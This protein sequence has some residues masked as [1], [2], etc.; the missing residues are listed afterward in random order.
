MK[1]PYADVRFDKSGRET[2]PADREALD[3]LI[4]EEKPT[5]VLVL[6]HG[7]NN[8]PA[9]ARAL[10]ERLV[11]SLAAVRRDVPG[12]RGRRFVVAGMLWPSILWAPPEGDGRGAGVGGDDDALVDDIRACIDDADAT[13]ALIALVPELSSSTQ[14]QARFVEILRSTLPDAT[15]GEDSAA[16]EA[17]READVPTLIDA[18]AA[19]DEETVGAPAV[20]GAAAID[21]TGLPPLVSDEGTG[22]GIFDR[23]LRAGRGLVNVTTYYTMKERAGVVGRDGIAPLLERLH[24]RT[25]GLRLHLVGHSFGGR[26]VTAA[27]LATRAP[28]ASMSLLQAAYSHF[29]M[30]RSYNDAGD[31]GAFADVPGKVAGPIVVT[32]TENDRAVGRAY[33]VASRLARQIG[34]ALGDADDPYGG[35]GRNGAQKTPGARTG[36]LGPVGADYSFAPGRVTSLLSDAFVADHSDVTGRE[37]AYAVLVAAA[38]PPGD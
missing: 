30:A 26:A 11:A 6:T 12:A 20:G 34:V 4:A 19:L 13:E 24:E 18:A 22:A 36:R 15:E 29:G 35:I 31:D 3:A 32:H 5:D 8:S 38:P 9:Q 23:I 27:A 1:L 37:V 17:L 16:F 25:P 21:P 7:W 10:Y 33:P 14:A 28:I 2:D